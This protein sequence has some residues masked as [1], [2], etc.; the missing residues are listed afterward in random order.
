M[1]CLAMRNVPVRLTERTRCHS[2]WSSVCTG[3]PPATPAALTM[4]SIRPRLE[5]VAATSSATEGSSA[6][7]TCRNDQDL[8]NDGSG[9]RS[10]RSA[11]TTV[12]PSSSSRSAHARPMP[13]AAP[14]TITT[15]FLSPR[16]S[17]SPHPV[18]PA[19]CPT[20]LYI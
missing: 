6:T 3:P 19:S 14:V 15:L 5:T 20:Y 12:A 9:A 11:P 8:P 4:P 18:R 2:S 17:L 16:I 13:E 7:S 10:A 1:T